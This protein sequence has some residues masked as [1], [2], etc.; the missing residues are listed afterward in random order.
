MGGAKGDELESFAGV[1]D[2]VDN[3]NFFSQH[4]FSSVGAAVKASLDKILRFASAH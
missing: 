3:E 4:Q 2:L 1:V